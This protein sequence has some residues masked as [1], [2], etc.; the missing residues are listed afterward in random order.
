[1]I[2]TDR[3]RDGDPSN[4]LDSDVTRADWWHGGDLQA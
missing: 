1:M 3:F 4:D 2:M